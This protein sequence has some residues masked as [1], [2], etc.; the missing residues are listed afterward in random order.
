MTSLIYDGLLYF[1]EKIKILNKIIK[2]ILRRN[3]DL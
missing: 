1:N 2:I 3:I